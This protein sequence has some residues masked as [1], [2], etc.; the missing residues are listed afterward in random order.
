M[1]AAALQEQPAQQAQPP[2]EPSQ[3]PAPQAPPPS[4]PAQAAPEQSKD[5]TKPAEQP[6][7]KEAK[8]G[9]SAPPPPAGQPP[10]DQQ[11]TS[12]AG[13]TPPTTKE[14]S[15]LAGKAPAKKKP[16]K[17]KPASSRVVVRQGGTSDPTVELSP[18]LTPEQASHQRQSTDQLL[19]V[20]ELN[21][22]K[23]ATRQIRPTERETINQ[24][25]S[26]TDQAKAA[27]KAGDLERSHNL[28]F[29]AYLL[30][31]ELQRN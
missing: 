20:T 27:L 16:R 22:K 9:Q 8:P 3:A 21:L 29:K 1:S 11:N 13:P 14:S 12:P 17:R 30:S 5:T 24:I 10:P 26:Y 2:A 25:H 7:T 31:D 28:A 6:D 4:E 19:A 15:Q 23:V 18:S